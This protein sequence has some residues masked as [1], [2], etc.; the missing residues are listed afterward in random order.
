MGKIE[1]QFSII[2]RIAVELFLSPNH[3]SM[4][5]KKN[6]SA[7]KISET[8]QVLLTCYLHLR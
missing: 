3:F 5:E 4:F 8:L 7:V 6:I 1:F 2:L